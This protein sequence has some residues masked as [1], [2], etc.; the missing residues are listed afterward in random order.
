MIKLLCG[1]SALL[2]ANSGIV[3]A[4]EKKV[5]LGRDIVTVQYNNWGSFG[6]MLYSVCRQHQTRI[7]VTEFYKIGYG[8]A[9]SSYDLSPGDSIALCKED[10]CV[11]Y[12]LRSI[13]EDCI[14]TFDSK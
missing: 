2:L 10:A 8:A 3:H 1:A 4:E 7:T 11:R 13:S 5:A 12:M 6:T 14:A 9:S